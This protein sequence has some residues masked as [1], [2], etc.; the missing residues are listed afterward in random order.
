MCDS[1]NV[2]LHFSCFRV[3][4]FPTFH[5][6]LKSFY[7]SFT[8]KMAWDSKGG[9]QRHDLKVILLSDKRYQYVKTSLTNLIVDNV[10]VFYIR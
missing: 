10:D 7:L 4:V 2:F 6:T 5:I 3:Y 8:V 9:K 1:K